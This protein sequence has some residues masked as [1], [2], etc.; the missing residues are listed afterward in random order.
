MSFIFYVCYFII[1]RVF[2]IFGTKLRETSATLRDWV[3]SCA[4]YHLHGN[5]I[6]STFVLLMVVL[7]AESYS[8][9]TNTK[10]QS[11]AELQNNFPTLCNFVGVKFKNRVLMY[12]QPL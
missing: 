11:F 9:L 2:F 10:E 12:I 6:I 4:V 1:R 3:G 7:L 5:L 8:M